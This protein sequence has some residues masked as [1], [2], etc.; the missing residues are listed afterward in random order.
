MLELLKKH[1]GYESFRPLQEEVIEYCLS[2]KD[3][4][5]LM[6]TG[7]GKSL[8]YQIPALAFPGLTIVVSPLVALMKDQVDAL[9]ANGISAAFMNSTLSPFEIAEVERLASSGRLKLLYL[10][11]ERLT[12]SSVRRF[13]QT[14]RISLFAVDEAHCISEWGHDFRPDYR[15][16][17]LRQY[18]PNIP[19]IAL[20]ATANVRVREDIVSHLGLQDGR[21]FK[22]SFNRPNLTYRVLPKKRSFDQLLAEIKKRPDQS[23]IV[24]CFSRKSTEKIAGDLRANGIKA[25]AY[26][27]GLSAQER[28]RVQ[29]RFIRDQTPVI[30]ATIA[31]GMG[32]DKPDVRLVA[33][34]D[35][36]KS[37]EG[38]YQET[39][40]AGR[41]GLP[42]DCLLFFS[43]GDRVKHEFFIR[44][45]EDL[46]ERQRTR[47]QLQ[48]V[49]K[50]GELH[51]CRRA[52]LL[53]YFGETWQEQN[54]G[55]CD[56]CVPP[57]V[58]QSLK[59]VP[60]EFD[61]DLFEK[62]RAL[63]R[64]LAEEGGVPPYMIFG[65]K[66]LQE[67]SRTFP[68]SMERL[69]QIFGVG[70]GKLTQFGEPFLDVIRSYAAERGIQ[71]QESTQ[72]IVRRKAP[73]KH[74]LT[75]TILESVRLFEQK[76]TP[77][78]I[79][80]MRKISLGTV[81]Q[82]LEAALE[83]G[84]NLDASHVTL[85]SAERFERIAE[86]FENTKNGFLAPVRARLGDSYS[87]DELRLARFLL[88][89][90]ARNE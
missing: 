12:K 14:L 40:R 4:L 50:Y 78:H 24:Y 31:F 39:G 74:A 43:T 44:R 83:Q 17:L 73:A 55:A 62:L 72:T 34:M 38:Y 90:R 20:T 30:T 11:P 69:S 3:S 27:A 52:F 26:H 77:E 1:F 85:P 80:K 63:R 42:S 53:R 19:I 36:P 32:I 16:L 65:D 8:C 68:Q 54:C 28:T 84:R 9:K 51:S 7:G 71:E 2:G 18:F 66:T 57:A 64:S 88:K 37:V 67:M 59:K 70:K 79:A 82:H 46:E 61:G 23:V 81:L 25:S 49:I 33:H 22:S 76:E 75:N 58:S 29:E 13:L 45:M 35:L 6:P 47:L 41:D 86:A 21:V 10:A 5:V 15:N 60:A 56:I 48:E 87:Y 89:T